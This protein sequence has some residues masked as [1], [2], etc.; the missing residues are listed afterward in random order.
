MLCLPLVS[1]SQQTDSLLVESKEQV[2]QHECSDKLDS[3]QK[4]ADKQL[5]MWLQIM[6]GLGIKEIDSLQY[7]K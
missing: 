5:F 2:I 1:L 4:S 3:L 7:E 6:E